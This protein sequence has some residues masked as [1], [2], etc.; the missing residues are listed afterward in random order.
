MNTADTTGSI[1]R[2][3]PEDRQERYER[4]LRVRRQTM[5]DARVACSAYDRQPTS[6][7]RLA[8]IAALQAVG[9][10]DR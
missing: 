10:T 2:P 9:R 5:L 1:E 6:E 8:A 3:V 7:H 4:V